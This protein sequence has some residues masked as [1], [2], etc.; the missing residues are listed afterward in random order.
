MEKEGLDIA[1]ERSRNLIEKYN[2]LSRLEAPESG[3]SRLRP[4]F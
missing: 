4:L 2:K 1:L 3:S